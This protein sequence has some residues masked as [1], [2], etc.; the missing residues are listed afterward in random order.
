MCSQLVILERRVR[1]VESGES[2]VVL[3][4]ILLILPQLSAPDNHTVGTSPQLMWRAFGD[5]S[6]FSL[7]PSPTVCFP[8]I[9][10]KDRWT[11]VTARSWRVYLEQQ[12][13]HICWFWRLIMGRSLSHI[14][15]K[16]LLI[17]SGHWTG[18]LLVG[19]SWWDWKRSLPLLYC[20]SPPSTQDY[21]FWVF[22]RLVFF[23]IP[24]L[25]FNHKFFEN[26][27]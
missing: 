15:L 9:V 24:F 2:W 23:Y 1:G 21:R 14:F 17:V 19:N 18:C 5:A 10:R 16:I 4:N 26:I 22:V 7:S 11:P 20:W 3:W 25:L 12:D 27:R 6:P 8:G 13:N